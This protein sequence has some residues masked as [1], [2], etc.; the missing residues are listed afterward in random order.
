VIK[1]IPDPVIVGFTSGIGVIIWIG[2]WKDFFGL[3]PAADN[4]HFHDK[5]LQP[6]SRPSDRSTCIPPSSPGSRSASW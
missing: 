2:Q 3:K 6:A 5:L 4:G 1:Y